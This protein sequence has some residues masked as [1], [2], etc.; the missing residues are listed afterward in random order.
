MLALNHVFCVKIYF[1]IC[2]DYNDIVLHLYCAE[3][4]LFYISL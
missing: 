3:S 1:L 4:N 2:F